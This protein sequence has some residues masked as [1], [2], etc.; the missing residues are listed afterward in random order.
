[1]ANKLSAFVAGVLVL[2]I[3]GGGAWLWYNYQ[4]PNEM[5]SPDEAIVKYELQTH[6]YF[7]NT[8]ETTKYHI[9]ST[10]DLDDFYALYSNE[11]AAKTEYLE[12]HDLFIEVRVANS[13]S[14]KYTL[15]AVNFN[16]NTVNFEISTTSPEVG[17]DDMAF[18]YFV[19]VVPK[20]KVK[21]LN[22]SEWRK[23]SEVK[24]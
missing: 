5:P 13:G 14:I 15:D 7:E 11:L 12:H 24:P 8:P 20:E 17:T 2:I 21:N 1:M 19:A 23:P 3:L 16:N 18:W 6:E 4:K 10:K 22:T 9:S